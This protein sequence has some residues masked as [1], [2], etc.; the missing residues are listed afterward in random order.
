MQLISYTFTYEAYD[1]LNQILE[2]LRE[3]TKKLGNVIFKD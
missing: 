2:D 3:P 1:F